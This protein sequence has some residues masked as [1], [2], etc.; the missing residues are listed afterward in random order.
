MEL[1]F[2]RLRPSYALSTIC[3]W[4]IKGQ[5]RSP[6]EAEQLTVRLETRRSHILRWAVGALDWYHSIW[7]LNRSLDDYFNRA[8]C[9][10]RFAARTSGIWK[11]IARGLP[12]PVGTGADYAG[13]YARRR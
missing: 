7:F 4:A 3:A 2:E 10:P 8:D 11:T 12:V 5:K 6:T 1:R 9:D 13:L